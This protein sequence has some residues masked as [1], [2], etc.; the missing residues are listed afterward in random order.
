[1]IPATFFQWLS[2]EFENSWE[3]E[4]NLDCPELIIAFEEEMRLKIKE[5]AKPRFL[6]AAEK[7]IGCTDKEGF[8]QFLIK[9]KGVDQADLVACSEAQIKYPQLVQEF[10]KERLNCNQSS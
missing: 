5:A 9:W 7:I 8:M 2:N 1:M 4:E 6:R 10:Y 3:N